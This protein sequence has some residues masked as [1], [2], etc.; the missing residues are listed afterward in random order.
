MA[1]HSYNIP[2][3][4][5]NELIKKT[6]GLIDESSL[7]EIIT[8][9]EREASK[10]YFDKSSQGNFFRVI[11]SLFDVVTFLKELKYYDHHAE[12][13]LAI[14]SNS[15]YLSDI[16][17]QNPELLYQVFDEEY[18][19]KII[20]Y[21]ELKNELIN[22]LNKYK[23]F[24]TK[25]KLIR[26]F[27]KRYVLKIGLQDIL[28]IQDL[29]TITFEL[30]VLAKVILSVLFDLCYNEI[31]N[32]YDIHLPKNKFTIC[33]LGKLGGEEL[34]YSSDVDLIIFYDSNT[35]IKKNQKDFHEILTE[36]IQL[37]TFKSTQMTYNG[38]IYRIDFRLR[39]DGKY[40]PL[41]K[42][43]N[44][45][46]KYYET[47]GEDWEKQM[48][49]KLNYVFGDKNLYNQFKVFVDSYVYQSVINES[50]KEKVKLMKLNI[51]KHNQDDD[52][53]TFVGG[54]RDIEFSVQ[55]LQLLNGNKVNE[56]KNGNTLETLKILFEKK[57]LTKKE[58]LTFNE[59]YIFYRRTEHFLQL[60]N[61][62]QTHSIPEEYE[63]RYKLCKYLGIDT[64]EKLLEEIELR[65]KSVR[66]IYESI[67]STSKKERDIFYNIK[68]LDKKNATKNLTFLKTG[69]GIIERKEFDS[70]TIS[71]F[72]RIENHL[73][74]YLANCDEPDK[75]L[76]NFTKAIQF[77]NYPSIW[78][79]EFRNRKFFEQF[80]LLCNFS[81]KAVDYLLSNKSLSELLLSRKVYV[82]NFNDDCDI[83]STKDMLFIL[84]VQH[85]LKLI[86]QKKFSKIIGDFIKYKINIL[87]SSM[88]LRN[89]IFI[90]ALGSLG[91]ETVNF[92][93]DIDLIVVQSK[94]L[95][96]ENNELK[97]QKFLQ[98]LNNELQPF[99][100]DFRLRPEGK[101]SQLVWDLEN[102]KNYLLQRAEVW[103]FQSLCK[104]KFIAG[105]KNLYDEFLNVVKTSL[106]KFNCDFIKKEIFEMNIKVVKQNDKKSIKYIYGGLT[107]IEFFFQYIILINYDK[108]SNKNFLK[109]IKTLSSKNEDVKK[110]YFN[111]SFF[112]EYDL[113]YQNIF[114]KKDSKIDLDDDKLKIITKYLKLNSQNELVKKI[115][116]AIKTN[117]KIFEKYLS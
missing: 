100:I 37:F 111:Y 87:F 9:L 101:K 47:R 25:V 3:D 62:T 49:I 17:V 108:L 112:K 30:S 32:K 109:K 69:K 83:L 92:S 48:L 97:F 91:A 1:I 22:T 90:A 12:I 14:V 41:C 28:R 86:N 78:F 15:N 117:Q 23:N 80:L 57:L 36:T 104:I 81:Q 51:E 84:S 59:A 75:V 11:N 29:K 115:E 33:S 44:D 64:I 68:F 67:L 70:R 71:A 88:F 13:L 113:A 60:M 79:G 18:L 31:L 34:N 56:L 82:K 2:D 55:V 98:T 16:I 8:I 46:I 105:N 74:S 114:N 77:F 99:E 58:F 4:L 116:D 72:E 102:Y 10:Y 65:R 103:E 7:N 21:D 39:P 38:F 40:S 73:Y 42:S 20:S 52:V 107:T 26:Q 35:P 53:K 110:M 95:K 19:K 50:I 94:S 89:E 106:K 76:D 24:E 54:I 66:K 63:I 6:E 85:S 27:K 43:M 61:D 96:D 93:S 45:Y 5:I